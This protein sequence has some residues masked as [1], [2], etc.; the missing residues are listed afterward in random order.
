[1]LM[2]TLGDTQEQTRIVERHLDEMRLE[3]EG[4]RLARRAR[5]SRPQRSPRTIRR[6]LGGLLI[7]AGQA[8]AA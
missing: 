6:T 5:G 1:M 2:G 4:E 7:A 8:L 3:A